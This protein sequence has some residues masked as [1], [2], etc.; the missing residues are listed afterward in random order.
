MEFYE[1]DFVRYKKGFETRKEL[2]EFLKQVRF[3]D[4]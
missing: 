4:E 1:L 3:L 2:F